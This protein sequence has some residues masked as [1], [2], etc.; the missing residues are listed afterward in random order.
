MRL[1]RVGHDHERGGLAGQESTA[2]GGGDHPL[3]GR[4]RLPLRRLRPDHRGNPARGV[5][6]FPLLRAM[7]PSSS[8]GYVARPLTRRRFVQQFAGGLAVLWLVDPNRLLAQAETGG[9]GRGRGANR[10]PPE[11]AAWLHIAAD[12]TVTVFSGKTEV[13]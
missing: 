3:H 7:T 11:L 10:R 5:T 2:D 1:L 12:G 4:Q 6:A 13:G 9:G 8:P